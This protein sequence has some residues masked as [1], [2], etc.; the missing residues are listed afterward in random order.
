MP[1]N[2][3]TTSGGMKVENPTA[4]DIDRALAEPRD[5]DWYLNLAR[6]DDDYMEAMLDRGDLWLE[7]EHDGEFLQA[8]SRLDDA[9][10]KSMLVSFADGASGWRDQALWRAPPKVPKRQEIPIPVIAGGIAAVLLGAVIVA[11]SGPWMVVAFALAFPGVIATAALTK[12]REVKRAASW[13]K[14]SGR[15]VRSEMGTETRQGKEVKV[16]VVE[17]EFSIGFHPCRGTRIS[18]AEIVGSHDAKA[19]LARYRA[20]TAV[21]VY[22]DPADISK[23]VIE[24]ELPPYFQAIWIAVVV[25]LIAIAAGAYWFLIR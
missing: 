14:A 7:C 12:M 2:E 20:G 19:L 17:Y 4:D 16:P 5:D 24:R 23:S 11:G 15:I 6:G 18:L 22:Y 1:M 3:L 21:P 8:V 10:A 13:T 9:L 25:M